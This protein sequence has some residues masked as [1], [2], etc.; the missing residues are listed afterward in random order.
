MKT[1]L[2]CNREFKS[3]HALATHVRRSHNLT[4][5]QYKEKF[6]LL[7]L[8]KKCGK[9]ISKKGTLSGF[10]NKCRNRN[11]A[12]NPFYGKKHDRNMIENTKKKL[13]LIS[14]E[15]WKN[16]EYRK[17]VFKNTTGKLR[18][19]GFKNKQKQNAIKQ[20]KNKEQ[21]E[22][23]SQIMTES[24]K[25]GK[26]VP[27]YCSESKIEKAFF[28]EVQKICPFS[29][30]KKTLKIANRNITPDVLIKNRIV[31]EFFGDYWHANPHKYVASD[32]VYGDKTA[33]Q[34]WKK[35]KERISL[36]EENGY[37]VYVVWESDYK[38]NKDKVLKN[39][40]NMLNW[41]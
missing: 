20:F 27:N 19:N 9:E 25:K 8:C 41:D 16:P 36:L 17:T 10:C 15:L 1:C 13:S 34:I 32:K 37:D 7:V 5:H 39:I 22:I 35:D 2:I 28:E 21:R 30:V 23:R 29:I 31:F 12:K 4:S 6:G 18:N 33:Q 38:N 11:G 40:N 14:K 24:W 26:I 3:G